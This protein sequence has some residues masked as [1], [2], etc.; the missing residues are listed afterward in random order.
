MASYPLHRSN[1]RRLP[2]DYAGD[3]LVWDIDKTYLDTHFSTWR[4]MLSIPF[5]FAVD[6]Q[7]IPGAVPLLHALRRGPG[8]TPALTPLY[9]I[10]ASPLQLRGVIER[11]M[12]MDGVQYDGICFQDQ[13]QLALRGR[14]GLLKDHTAY[15]LIA[16]LLQRQELPQHA[17]MLLFGDDAESDA[18]VFTLF[19]E[20]C[21]GLRQGPL[22]KRLTSREVP[23]AQVEEILALSHDLPRQ[24]SVER[25]YIHLTQRSSP[26]RFA[27]FG[28]LL[29]ATHDFLEQAMHLEHTG[30]I[31][32]ADV[33]TVAHAVLGSASVPELQT[34]LMDSAA[35]LGIHRTRVDQW[36]QLLQPP[37]E[38]TAPV[39]DL[40]KARKVVVR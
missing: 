5:E 26:E 21:S 29:V 16:L 10:S 27:S 38:G 20:I 12:I 33:V 1:E 22:R 31:S 6:K 30:R 40:E 3:V 18:E 9:F 25:I 36:M 34:R 24:D 19:A 32:M 28:P 15:K 2:A 4:G 17:R 7:A 35:R 14:I 39:V 37:V 8:T 23:R 11:K 13:V